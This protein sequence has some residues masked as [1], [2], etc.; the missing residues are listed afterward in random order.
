MRSSFIGLYAA[1]TCTKQPCCSEG[2]EGALEVA[3][4]GQNA[5]RSFSRSNSSIRANSAAKEAHLLKS[6]II[7]T[8]VQP[9]RRPARSAAAS[10]ALYDR[11]TGIFCPRLRLL[12]ANCEF[13][14]V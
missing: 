8:R 10:H 13:E 6:C 14:V 5:L 7:T 2:T 3:V 12:S 11:L 9:L 4:Q 1:D